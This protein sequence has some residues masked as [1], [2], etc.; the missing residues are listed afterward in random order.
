MHTSPEVPNRK[1]KEFLK[2]RPRKPPDQLP[3][4]TAPGG[5]LFGMLG[6]IEV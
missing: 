6:E 4:R 5:S 3:E 1:L 2:I